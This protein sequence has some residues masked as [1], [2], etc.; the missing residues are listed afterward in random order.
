M[1][2]PP[3]PCDAANELLGSRTV[4]PAGKA[5]M[6][7]RGGNGQ[8]GGFSCRSSTAARTAGMTA[9]AQQ[10]LAVPVGAGQTTKPSIRPPVA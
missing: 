10:R 5:M 1:A 8:A 9:A 3:L 6:A 7:G 2:R 4:V